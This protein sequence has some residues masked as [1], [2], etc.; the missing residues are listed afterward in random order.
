[1][2]SLRGDRFNSV[3]DDA[4]IPKNSLLVDEEVHNVGPPT[5]QKIQQEKYNW[6]LGLSATPERNFDEEG[7]VVIDNYFEKTVYSYSMQQAL[8]DNRLSPYN[9]YVY[10]AELSDEEFEE[11]QSLT[12]R[13][14][15]LRG[16]KDQQTTLQT[17]NRIDND[18]Q[19]I[20]TLLF[21]RARI[22][23]NTGSKVD[24]VNQIFSNYK[25][26]RCLIYCADN[27]QLDSIHEI[28]LNH[29]IQHQIYTANTPKE[30]RQSSLDAIAHGRIPVILAID[31]LDEG[32]DVPVVDEAIIIA[33]SS[34]KRQF[35]QRRG[36]ILRKAPGK[37]IAQLM[38]VIVVPPPSVGTEGRSMLRGELARAK[39]MA[40]LAENKYDA[41]LN[42]KEHTEKYGVLLSELLLGVDND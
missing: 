14:I 31:C 12:R 16:Q 19:D 4:G 1:M 36:R 11:Y 9:Y 7:T 6:R 27:N 40:E 13:I 34:N 3:Q 41:L 33:S 18:T 15:S 24:V 25:P 42:I 17:N 5:K 29:H 32:V 22:L 21:R 8:E 39:E 26:N 20:E 23:K 2:Q 37:T 38:D 35:I 30:Q 28:L 10:F